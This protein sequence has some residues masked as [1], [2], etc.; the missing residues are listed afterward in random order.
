MSDDLWARTRSGSN[1]G[2]GFHYQDAVATEV[3]LRGWRGELRVRRIVPEGLDDVSVELDVQWLHLQAKSRRAHRG[4]FS[5]AEV[6]AVWRPLAERLKNDPAAHVGLVLERPLHGIETGFA[7]VLAGVAPPELEKEIAAAI[8]GVVTVGD[9][10]ARTHVIVMPA[11]QPTAIGLLEEQLGIAPATC[12]AHYGA[13]RSKMAA[14]ADENGVRGANDAAGIAQSDIAQLLEEVTLAVDPSA[15][16]EA[17]RLG[18]CESVDFLTPVEDDR[19]YHGVDVVAGHVV[20]GLPLERPELVADLSDGMARQ[21][22]ALAVGPSGTGKS[23]L[24]WLAAFEMRHE[25][26][27]YRV[28]RLREEDVQALVRLAKGLEPTGARVGF[29]VDDLGQDDRAG[30]DRLHDEIRALPNVFVLGA[31]REEDLFLLRTAHAAAQIRPAMDEFLAERIWRELHDRGETTWPHWREPFE[32]SEGLLLEYGHLLTEGERLAQTVA[33]QVD[34][35]VREDRA[36]ELDLLALISTADAFGAKLKIASIVSAMEVDPVAMKGALYRLVNEHLIRERDGFLGGLHELRSRHIMDAVHAMPPPVLHDTVQRVIDLLDP[37]S[38]Q[39]FATRLMSSSNEF[40]DAV[41]D[42]VATRLLINPDPSLLAAALQALRLVSYQRLAAAWRAVIL[43][44]DVA[45]SNAGLL[46]HFAVHGG[47]LDSFPESIR[48]AVARMQQIALIDLRVPLLRRVAP[49]ISEALAAAPDIRTAAVALAALGDATLDSTIDAAALA[50]LI[51]RASLDDLRLLLETAFAAGPELAIA[52]A[53]AAGGSPHLLARLEKERPW[54]RNARLGTDE[55]GRLTADA[56]Y[57]YVVES[58]QPNANDAVVE[59]SRY[60]LAFAPAAEIAVCRAVDATGESAGLGVP[61]AEKAMPRRNL[62]TRAEIARNRASIRA[63]LASVAA[64]TMTEHQQAAHDIVVDMARVV[65]RAGDAWARARQ[66]NV[67]LST[68]VSNLSRLVH[69]LPPPPVAFDASGSLEEGDLPL[70]EPV[71]SVGAIVANNLL[72]RLFAG[73]RVAPLIAHLIPEVEQL[74]EAE[75]WR[76]LDRPPLKDVVTLKEALADLHAVTAERA[77]GDP[78]TLKVLRAAGT[79]GLRAAAI[80][81]RERAERRMSMT[82]SEIEGDLREAGINAHVLRREGPPDEYRWPNDDF[83]VLVK[84]ETIFHWQRTMESIAELCRPLL[85]D[86]IGFR[87]APVLAGRIAASCGVRVLTNV[88]TDNGARD[89]PNASF[90]ILEETLADT[91][92][93]GLGGLHEAS[94]IVGSLRRDELH[95]DEVAAL[96]SVLTAADEAIGDIAVIAEG[97]RDQLPTEVLASF[98]RFR[99]IVEEQAAAVA[100]GERDHPNLAASFIE[101]LRGRGDDLFAEQI[102]VLGACVEWDVA[103]RGAWLRVCHALSLG[104]DTPATV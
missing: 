13:L 15:L 43:G 35:R 29:V 55:E 93:R 86:R 67:P 42:A 71:S 5:F 54:V 100:R 8:G 11:L 3:A 91:A 44:E 2:R 88:F 97:A 47:T 33:G 12:V 1:A 53:D 38:L 60:L 89:W 87:M 23:A 104:Q 83:L 96:T 32:L 75:R 76:L 63:A 103:P 98:L 61:M 6:R 7:N 18:I 50:H 9:F 57:A 52:L 17:V 10:L 20:A 19:F 79:N 49:Q 73:D 84:T 34:R 31:S 62:P 28:Q 82:A 70:T 64:R 21:R 46:A 22:V 66:P 25:L 51:D 30:F 81:A 14:L 72:P 85:A 27:W 94:G 59:L 65:V 41:I 37:R 45:R 16:D 90:P 69:K 80:V 36:L 101:G 68:A 40:D 26:R 78:E 99:T 102:A 56:K 39:T 74:A 4:E 24:I 58:A 95:D 48:K 92:R 77:L